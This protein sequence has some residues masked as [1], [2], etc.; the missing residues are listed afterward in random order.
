MGFFL[1][2]KEIGEFVHLSLNL[3]LFL[4]FFSSVCFSRFNCLGR[5][6]EATVLQICSA[7]FW[8]NLIDG[9]SQ[10]WKEVL[11]GCWYCH[12]Y[13]STRVLICGC[14][15]IPHES[16]TGG[17]SCFQLNEQWIPMFIG[18]HH[19]LVGYSALSSSLFYARFCDWK[20]PKI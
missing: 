3:F 8:H 7:C 16:V 9:G 10:N 15:Y 19:E 18:I 11:I 20:L 2:G 4:F 17:N 6:P 1:T 12:T 14:K 5:L 13:P